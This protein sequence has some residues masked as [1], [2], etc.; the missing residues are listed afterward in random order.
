MGTVKL[1]SVSFTFPVK[2]FD[3]AIGE[4]VNKGTGR[5]LNPVT[6][7][8]YATRRAATPACDE[9]RAPLTRR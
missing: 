3:R 7:F 8:S 2:W 6:G 5:L 9:L 4:G 1:F